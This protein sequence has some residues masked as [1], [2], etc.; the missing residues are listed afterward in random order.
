MNITYDI[1]D[2]PID[3]SQN[4]LINDSSNCIIDIFNN[5][6]YNYDIDNIIALRIDYDLNYNYSYL[7]NILEF[8]KIK[9]PKNINKEKII[10]LIVDYEIDYKNKQIVQE[11]KTLF[12]QFIE[13][14]NHQFFNKFIIGSL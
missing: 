1:I 12:T 10:K 6:K 3:I 14:K 9:K 11:R 8:Y 4:N 5:P 2:I 7:C 13:L